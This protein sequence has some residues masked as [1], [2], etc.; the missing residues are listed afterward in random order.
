MCCL[1]EAA[2]QESFDS[3]HLLT[4]CFA[5]AKE[6][7]LCQCLVLKIASVMGLLNPLIFHENF[8]LCIVCIHLSR[9]K[10]NFMCEFYLSAHKNLWV[11]FCFLFFFLPQVSF[12]V[13]Q[14]VLI[15]FFSLMMHYILPARQKGFVCL[16]GD[17]NSEIKYK[18]KKS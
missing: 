15:F 7:P 18:F 14:S 10:N 17:N 3:I 6:V 1:H 16:N 8:L 2:K 11:L 9:G 13:L 4:F 5:F 12:K